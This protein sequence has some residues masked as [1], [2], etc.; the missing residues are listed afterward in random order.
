MGEPDH[1]ES[2]TESPPRSRWRKRLLFGGLIVLVFA[3][4]WVAAFVYINATGAR[5]LQQVIAELDARDPD[6]RLENL[7]AKR[8]VIPDEQNGALRILAAT[9]LMPPAGWSAQNDQLFQDLKPERQLNALQIKALDEDLKKAEPALH[10]AR[11][12]K[13]LPNGRFPIVWSPDGIGT[14]IPHVQDARTIAQ[15]LAND[16]LLRAQEKDLKGA[17]DSC[18]ALLNA[19]RAIGDEPTLISMLVRV[20]IQAIA[21][22]KL[23]RV[24]AQGEPRD[25]D[26]AA[27]QHLL[28]DEDKQPLLHIAALGERAL[29]F[30]ATQALA[31]GWITPAALANFSLGRMGQLGVGQYTVDNLVATLR[32]GSPTKSVAALLEFE[33]EFVETTKLP[34]A[35]QSQRLQQLQATMPSQPLLVQMLVPALVK[36]SD[37]VQRSRAVL[38]TAIAAMAAE[39]YRQVQGRWPAALA[40]L[41]P[42]YLEKV[43]VDPFDQAPLRLRKTVDGLVIYSV[44]PDGQDNGGNITSNPMQ[45]GTDMG[46]LLWDADKRRQA[47]EAPKPTETPV[48]REDR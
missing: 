21:V 15:L 9:P 46:F 31:N 6:W 42:K 44:G 32:V 24:L 48:D 40:D 4:L 27:I 13:D 37:A 19:G 23:E 8:R 12:L 43:P 5:R 22:K 14:R 26:L 29:G 39:R 38:R 2:V 16:V 35:E 33:T 28:E 3:G 25:E 17:L 41:V 34:E 47:L 11:K 1:P 18:R 36:V 7:E 10:E 20:A 45:A 30:R